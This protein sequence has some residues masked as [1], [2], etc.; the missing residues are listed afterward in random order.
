MVDLVAGRWATH[1]RALALA[2]A[3]VGSAAFA[4]AVDWLVAGDVVRNLEFL[5]WHGLSSLCEDQLRRASLLDQVPEGVRRQL[6][7]SRRNAVARYLTQVGV[8]SELAP[9][10]ERCGIEYVVLK[11]AATREEVYTDP[12]LRST[13][14]IDL[15]VRETDREAVCRQLEALAFSAPVVARPGGHEVTYS[16]GRV[17]IDLHW[18]ILR[19]GRTRRPLVDALIRRRVRGPRAWRLDDPDTV[20][21]MLVHPAFTKYVCSRNM[22]LNRV[23]DLLRFTRARTVN[24]Q[25][26]GDLLTGSGLCT[27]AWCTL[28]WIGMLDPAATAAPDSFMRRICPGPMRRVYLEQWL[29]YDWPGRLLGRADWLIQGAFTLPL[30]DSGADAWRAL[31]HRA[32]RRDAAVAPTGAPA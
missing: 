26:V 18:D 8:W 23:V 25:R 29:V 1:A 13:G 7:S 32:L 24:W 19:P 12:S 22:G 10:L 6:L 31:S 3:D 14:D 11:G 4:A 30:H 20:F 21:L 5:E 16:R 2:D 9:A 17:D 28:R 27:A 15:L